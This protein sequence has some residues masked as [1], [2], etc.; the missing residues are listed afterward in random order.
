MAARS[1]PAESR[2]N[3][4]NDWNLGSSENASRGTD[5]KPAP[6]RP[7]TRV[8]SSLFPDDDHLLI[9]IRYHVFATFDPSLGW[10]IVDRQITKIDPVLRFNDVH[11]I[12]AWINGER[13]AEVVR[14]G[15]ARF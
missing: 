6:S 7:I 10:R 9:Y 15:H 5:T 11:Y 13:H 3:V 2:V 12:V 14:D 8:P 4:T 1:R